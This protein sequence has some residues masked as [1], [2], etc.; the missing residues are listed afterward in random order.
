MENTLKKNLSFKRPVSAMYCRS[1]HRIQIGLDSGPC[2]SHKG[3]WREDVL[4]NSFFISAADGSA[5]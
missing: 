2:T 4:L 1:I 5:G 3:T